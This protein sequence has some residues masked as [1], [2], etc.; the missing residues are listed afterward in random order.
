ML[1]VCFADPKFGGTN[2]VSGNPTP[3]GLS[4]GGVGSSV[5]IEQPPLSRR[6]NEG[7]MRGL[8]GSD[9]VSGRQGECGTESADQQGYASS[10]TTW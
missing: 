7:E 4:V 6:F 5:H 10:T 1:N 8:S 2:Q 9:T 3:S